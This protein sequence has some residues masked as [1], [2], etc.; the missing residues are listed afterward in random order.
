MFRKLVQ[1]A[2]YEDLTVLEAYSTK[3]ITPGGQI[4]WKSKVRC[5]CGREKEV[6]NYG[7]LQGRIKSCGW[8]HGTNIDYS[9][10]DKR[11][12]TPTYISWQCMVSRCY[13]PND[14]R[15][16]AYGAVGVSVCEQWHDFEMFHKDMGD[17]PEGKTI[18]RIKNELGYSPDNCRWAT[19]KE[20]ANNRRK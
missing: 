5:V 6:Y 15:F 2:T 1:G 12:R 16:Y 18:D 3:E 10:G 4:K 11:G 8:G 9:I 19:A 17:R 13:N 7:L 14:T 20:Q